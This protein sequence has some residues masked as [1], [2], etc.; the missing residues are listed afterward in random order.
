MKQ[1]HVHADRTF[2]LPRAFLRTT[3][4]YLANPRVATL[5]ELLGGAQVYMQQTQYL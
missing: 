5:E 1:I 4:F 3:F 2:F